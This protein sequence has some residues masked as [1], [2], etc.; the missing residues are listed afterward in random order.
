MKTTFEEDIGIA[1][2]HHGH[3]CAGMVL[4]I[5]MARH[6]LSLMGIE[7][8]RADRDLIVF[9]EMS[10]CPADAAY[11]V[12][13]IT[14]GRRRLKVVDMGKFAMTFVDPRTDR[15]FRAH[16]T[17]LVPH[18]PRG[19]DP[20]AFFSGLADEEMFA[21]VP[22]KV[23]IPPLEMPGAPTHRVTCAECG[24]EVLDGKEL[25]IEG[26][27]VCRLCGEMEAYSYYQLA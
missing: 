27:T 17:A 4:G 19:I 21:V 8:P 20:I 13:G 22:V 26:R 12:T 18:A 24:E 15:A 25:E 3:L 11:A 9:V 1:K 23:K 16:P 5:R 6:T 10:R 2:G 14:V 7:D